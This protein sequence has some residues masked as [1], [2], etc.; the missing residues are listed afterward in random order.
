[1]PTERSFVRTIAIKDCSQRIQAHHSKTALN[2]WVKVLSS[3]V[4]CCLKRTWLFVSLDRN[5]QYKKTCSS[6]TVALK[7]SSC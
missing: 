2:K 6:V 1:M 7:C 5:R 4:F 3:C